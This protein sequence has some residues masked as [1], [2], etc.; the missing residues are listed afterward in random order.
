MFADV[1]VDKCYS[2]RIEFT[3]KVNT[4]YTASKQGVEEGGV[5]ELQGRKKCM[6]NEKVCEVD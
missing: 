5:K 1:S 3:I 4:A 2:R 6:N